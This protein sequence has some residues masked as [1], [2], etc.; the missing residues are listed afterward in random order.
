MHIGQFVRLLQLISHG[1]ANKIF[2]CRP[3]YTLLN[4]VYV[5]LHGFTICVGLT[6][7]LLQ[8]WFQ[9]E[10]VVHPIRRRLERWER[11]R[12]PESAPIVILLNKRYSSTGAF[13]QRTGSKDTRFLSNP[14]CGVD[15]DVAAVFV[16]QARGL[17]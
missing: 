5:G 7:V 12:Q 10:H 9:V 4:D 2:I 16:S 15:A 3:S 1:D 8:A 13:P 14:N 17:S 6:L 11:S